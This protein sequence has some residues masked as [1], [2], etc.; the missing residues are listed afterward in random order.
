[1]IGALAANAVLFVGAVAVGF[2][3]DRQVQSSRKLA[4]LP[5]YLTLVVGGVGI[6]PIVLFSERFAVGPIDG[7][8]GATV[9][10]FA[11]WIGLPALFARATGV[12]PTG[13][14]C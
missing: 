6:A 2:L 4:A 8:I 13:T 9:V 14:G 3:V 10:S 12:E 11:L 1:M 5:W 7:L